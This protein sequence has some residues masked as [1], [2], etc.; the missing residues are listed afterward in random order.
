[1]LQ[2]RQQKRPS[3]HKQLSGIAQ[4]DSTN[5]LTMFG[6]CAATGS[7]DCTNSQAQREK[8]RQQTALSRKH[9]L[10]FPHTSHPDSRCLLLRRRR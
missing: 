1:M 5:N 10:L 8:V 7:T 6:D 3:T 4:V 2:A 9:R